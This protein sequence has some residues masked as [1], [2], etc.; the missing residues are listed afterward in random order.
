MRQIT[1]I[2]LFIFAAVI[3]CNTR[4]EKLKPDAIR[5]IVV[6]EHLLKLDS[7]YY[8]DTADINYK[9]LKAYIADDTS[10]FKKLHTDIEK[11][12][13]Y[14]QQRSNNDSC[15]HQPSLQELNVDEVYRFIYTAAFCDYQLNVTISRN[16]DSIKLHFILLKDLWLND[17]CKVISEYD[18]RITAKDWGNFSD[19]MEKADFW[20][21]R[22]NNGVM[23]LDGSTLVVM[24]FTKGY[25]TYEGKPK[26][27]YVYRW[28]YSTLSEPLIFVL[29]LSGNTQGCLTVK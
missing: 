16:G 5:D 21:L 12:S 26:F 25:R 3:S 24:G 17:T 15:I 9:V 19:L 6:K 14:R 13:K 1:Y 11:E 10:F 22:S 4:K 18:K 23:G 2:L 27:N 29:K 28:G 20:G 8:L 7:S